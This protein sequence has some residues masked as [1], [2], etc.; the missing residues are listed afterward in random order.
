MKDM[1]SKG[2]YCYKIHASLMK[3]STAPPP[4]P[5]PLLCGLPPIFT[6][7]SWV[8][9]SQPFYDFSKISTL[10]LGW[11]RGWFTLCIIKSRRWKPRQNQ[12]LGWLLIRLKKVFQRV[13]FFWASYVGILNIFWLKPNFC[14]TQVK[15]FMIVAK[16]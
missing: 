16:N 1:L 6:L 12:I 3:N 8:G 5:P 15:W 9:P 13:T 4:P 10:P 14:H 11:G 2:H 7:K